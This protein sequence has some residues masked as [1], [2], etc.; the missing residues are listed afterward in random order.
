MPHEPPNPT[1]HEPKPR[2]DPLRDLA[3]LASRAYIPAK[4]CSLGVRR[5]TT[6]AAAQYLGLP[7]RTLEDW[8]QSWRGGGKANV[9]GQCKGPVFVKVGKRVLY[10]VSELANFHAARKAQGL[11]RA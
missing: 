7:V 1:L 2:S 3:A 9:S 4:T 11:N 8:R 10:D 5:V 6:E